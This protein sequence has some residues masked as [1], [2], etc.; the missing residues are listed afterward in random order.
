MNAIMGFSQLMQRDAALSL[1]QR[2]NLTAISRSGEHLM[3]VINDVLEMSKIEAGRIA[4]A[5][6]TFDLRAL[7]DDLGIIFRG[8]I[9]NKKLSYVTEIEEGLVQ[10]VVSDESKLRQVL[11]NL[12]GNAVKFTHE[13]AVKVTVGQVS[14]P[15]DA[16]STSDDKLRLY[17]EVHDSGVGVAPEDQVKLFNKFEQANNQIAAEGGTGLGLA[18][19]RKYVQLMGGDIT[20]ESQLG[21]GSV[22]RFEI[23]AG[24]GD[25]EELLQRSQRGYVSSVVGGA[26]RFRILIVDDRETNRAVLARLLGDIG[27]DLKEAFDGQQ[28]VDLWGEWQPHL[29]LMDMAMPVMD[30]YEASRLIKASD[31]EG[32]SKLIAITAGA[33]ETERAKIM[34]LGVDDLVLKPYNEAILL[35][36]MAFHLGLEYVYSNEESKGRV[37]PSEVKTQREVTPESIQEIPSELRSRMAE[38]LQ[39]A[40][41]EGLNG[42][43]EE[44]ARIDAGLAEGLGNLAAKFQYDE[45]LRLL[46]TECEL[47]S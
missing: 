15:A 11:I 17:F 37:V 35:D 3:T 12:L 5:S 19:S 46:G 2:E 26:S 16:G 8:R 14:C 44:V 27:F 25:D 43:I 39:I 20:L 23:S 29:I 4:L 22:F 30:G 38:A 45:L 28:A 47:S 42:L 24:R 31:T 10:F 33:F 1:D 34:A 7:I 32:R 41:L 18:I 6:S 21:Q 9:E 36:R 40:D 13:G